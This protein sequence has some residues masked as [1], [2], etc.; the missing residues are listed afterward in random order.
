MDGPEDTIDTLGAGGTERE[1]KFNNM[2]PY[3]V[4]NDSLSI[5]TLTVC[6]PIPLIVMKPGP[7]GGLATAWQAKAVS[8][9]LSGVKVSWLV[10]VGLEP[11]R[12]EIFSL[13][14]VCSGTSPLSHVTSMSAN[15]TSLSVAGLR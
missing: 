3:C 10:K 8:S 1:R 11:S 15:L 7:S 13:P 4:N 6:F 12:A 14:P 9:V 2:S 5:G